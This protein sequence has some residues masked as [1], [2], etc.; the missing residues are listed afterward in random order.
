MP[1]I[2]TKADTMLFSYE[3]TY[4]THYRSYDIK[5]PVLTVYQKKPAS[6]RPRAP[7]TKNVH[8]LRE[9]REEVPFYLLHGRKAIL[10]TNPWLVQKKY[11]EPPDLLREEAQKT[12][13]RLVMTPAV[14]MD[15]IDDPNARRILCVDMYTTD[16][17]KAMRDA[18]TPHVN[19]EAPLP[20]LPAR[21][22]P[23]VL[24]K[25]EPSYVSPEWRMETAAWDNKQLRA[26]CDPTRDFWLSL[27]PFK[28]RACDEF[29]TITKHRRMLRQMKANRP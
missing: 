15:D 18:L 29:A 28:C 27:E 20:G 26:H 17:S 25:L 21:A 19:I 6:V 2:K 7:P 9:L 1:D 23:I 22:N 10:H 4:K 24:P 12:R 16:T 14:S 3:T 11:E 8:T 13:P 5:A